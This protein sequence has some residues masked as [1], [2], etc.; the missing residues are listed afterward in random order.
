LRGHEA[1]HHF[2]VA[3]AQLQACVRPNL[4]DAVKLFER[5][6]IDLPSDLI[7][8]A[9]PRVTPLAALDKVA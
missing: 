6:G 9:A 5:D 3:I 4:D 2:D 8:R 1:L 7:D